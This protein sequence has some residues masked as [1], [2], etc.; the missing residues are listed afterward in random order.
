M[1]RAIWHC[2][3]ITISFRENHCVT[4]YLSPKNEL[5][6][7]DGRTIVSTTDMRGNITFANPYFVEVSG[8]T[9]SEL[10][11]APQNIL[12]H[13]DMPAE[14]FADMWRCIQ[15]GMP[16][17]GMVKNRCK[18]GDYYWV[19][20]NVTPVIEQGQPTGYMSVRTKPS[21]EQVRA[22]DQLY[23]Q[24]KAGN[25]HRLAIVNGRAVET[26]WSARL[27]KP[28]NWA[29][30]PP[31]GSMHSYWRRSCC[32]SLPSSMPTMPARG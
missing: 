24:F 10:L 8:Y 2:G 27:K 28:A 15:S 26:H 22:A 16:W 21:R 25:P 12:R 32:C 23:Q 30:I 4:I 17:T 31:P 18:N 6:I 7:T 11:G 1:F 20:A 5:L 19:L 14:A 3:I 9:E 13:P 29:S